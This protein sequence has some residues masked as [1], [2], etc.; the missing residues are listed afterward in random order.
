MRDREPLTAS[1]GESA[2]ILVV[3]DDDDDRCAMK[4]VL[5]EHGFHVLEARNGQHALELMTSSRE[6]CLVIL[7]LEMP[8]MS[9]DELVDIM[10]RYHRLA[11]VPVL[12]VSGSKRARVPRHDKIVGTMAKPFELEALLA[13]VRAAARRPAPSN[14]DGVA[15]TGDEDGER[16]QASENDP[17][18]SR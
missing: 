4:E 10:R 13:T 15:V 17:P 1:Q 18:A 9:G 5:E 3:E 6:P 11:R 8:V 16:T 2:D 7:D 14:G 12:V